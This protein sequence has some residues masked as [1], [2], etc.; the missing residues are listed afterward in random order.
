M[1]RTGS[2][3]TWPGPATETHGR[4]QFVEVLGCIVLLF[5]AAA[6]QVVPAVIVAAFTVQP[7]ATAIGVAV[8]VVGVIAGAIA[9][10]RHRRRWSAIRTRVSAAGVT[11]SVLRR[12]VGRHA[13]LLGIAAL[14]G[15]IA[16]LA[17]WKLGASP[18]VIATLSSGDAALVV[19]ATRIVWQGGV[20]IQWR[21]ET[22]FPGRRAAFLVETTP[23]GSRLTVC[24][25]M[26]RCV[27]PC[28]PHTPKYECPTR[29][30]VAWSGVS[31]PEH[32]PAPEEAVLVEF[33]VPRGLPSSGPQAEWDLVVQGRTMWGVVRESF[34]VPI[35]D[36]P[37]PP[38]AAPRT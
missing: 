20:A 31:A 37:P 29:L 21:P 34:V 36:L 4:T 35:V 25:V 17:S 14:V 10:G 24:Q 33:D 8:G 1:V 16:A 13:P 12:T 30:V 28:D 5:A 22:L 15:G 32:D 3:Y 9:V 18:L 26:L 2:E 38:V 11:R 27:V 19:W 23:G 7:V 6:V